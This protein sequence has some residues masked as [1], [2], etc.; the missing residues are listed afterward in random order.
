MDW[1]SGWLAWAAAAP[2][3]MSWETLGI[4]LV[5]LVFVGLYRLFAERQRRTTLVRQALGGTV[6][7]QDGS[8]AGPGMRIW[9][10]QGTPPPPPADPGL[11][12]LL[13]APSAPAVLPPAGHH[14]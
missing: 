1:S 5:P 2:H 14:G 6:V 13:T 7:F 8:S 9:V 3:P 11:A 12:I 4:V 10:G